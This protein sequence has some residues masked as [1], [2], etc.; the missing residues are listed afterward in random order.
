[1]D[2]REVLYWLIGGSLTSWL[3]YTFLN[4]EFLQAYDPQVRRFGAMVA[5]TVVALAAYYV[6]ILAGFETAPV[7]VWEWLNV[8]IRV[9][10]PIF[11][12]TQAIHG[13]RDLGKNDK[14]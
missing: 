2:L 14:V 8:L 6:A 10:S 12:V 3:I 9:A 5:S 11:A 4:F 1:M 7:D 13:A